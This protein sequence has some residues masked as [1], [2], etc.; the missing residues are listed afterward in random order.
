VAAI[1]EQREAADALLLGRVTFEQMRGYWRLQTDDRTGIA[2]YLN[3]VSKYVVSRTL[4]DP[5][6]EHTTV[7][8]GAL[9]DGV[10]AL[11]SEPGND[12]VTTGSIAVV[13]G[14]DGGP[15][16]ASGGG[17]AVSL[18]HRPAALPDRLTGPGQAGVGSLPASTSAASTS[19]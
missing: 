2:D 9:V 4:Q 18:R 19:W 15:E 16:V 13:H 10:Q 8:H 11:K 5:Q 3:R 7:L 17:P 12:I 1:R 6:W 14:R